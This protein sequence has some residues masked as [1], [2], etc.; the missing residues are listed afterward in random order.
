M[1]GYG[2]RII[3][4]QP[5]TPK[6]RIASLIMDLRERTKRV[7]ETRPGFSIS[8]G[9]PTGTPQYGFMH[10]DKSTGHVYFYTELGWLT[11]DSR[12]YYRFDSGE[13][14]TT[15]GTFQETGTDLTFAVPPGGAFVNLMARVEV[16][17]DAAATSEV[18]WRI[19]GAPWGNIDLPFVR[20][21]VTAGTWR[22]GQSS[23]GSSVGAFPPAGSYMTVQLDGGTWTVRMRHHN[24]NNTGVN[25]RTR[26]RSFYAV[27]L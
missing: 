14:N 23:H 21:A 15:S 17:G 5:L 25:V 27:V 1:P 16:T 22:S 7:E 24:F 3:K 6:Q 19:E 26:R 11:A 9:P 13:S 2:Y 10:L 8:D 20:F 18:A 12:H 4:Q